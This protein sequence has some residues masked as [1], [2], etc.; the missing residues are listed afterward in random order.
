MKSTKQSLGLLAA[1]ALLSIALTPRVDAQILPSAGSPVVSAVSGGFNWDYDAVLAASSSV[2]MGDFFAVYDFGTGSLVSAPVGWILTTSASSPASVTGS[3]GSVTPTQTS[4][5]NFTFT[6]NG[7]TVFGPNNLGHFILFSTVG[8]GQASA[9][10]S[11]TH[12]Q[13]TGLSVAGITSTMTP[14]AT[15]TTTPEPASLSLMA[16][17]LVGVAGAGLR[18]R[19][20]A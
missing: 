3:G 9:W 15:I 10:A 14:S 16:T 17:G 20:K 1:T 19:K 7:A 2:R 11:L 18:R 13:N 4:A 6:Y 5:L 8:T 12:D